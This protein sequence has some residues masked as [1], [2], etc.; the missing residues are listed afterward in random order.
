MS[1]EVQPLSGMASR[2]VY[3][4]E[5][6][7][8]FAHLLASEGVLGVRIESMHLVEPFTAELQRSGDF[9]IHHIN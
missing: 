6:F 1:G 2:I 5:V 7:P 3:L 8:D 9:H 4:D